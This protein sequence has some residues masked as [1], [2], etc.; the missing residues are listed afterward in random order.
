MVLAG[1]VLA[2]AGAGILFL[3]VDRSLNRVVSDGVIR[4]GYAVEAPYA[5]LKPG[6]EVSGEAPEVAKVIAAQLGIPRIEWRQMEFDA[7]IP[8]L[9]A[10]RIDVIAAGMFITPERARRVH[11]SKPTLRV[12]Q[13]LL[14]RSGNPL[15]IHSYAQ[16]VSHPDLK[17][18]VLSGS[19]EQR[20]LRRMGLPEDRTVAVPDAR[21]GR[22]AVESGVAGC[23]ALSL[24]SVRWLALQGL[25][26][27]TEA[28]TE[29]AEDAPLTPVEEAALTA[30]AFH[31][32]DR[33]LHAAW[34]RELEQFIGR[35]GHLAILQL[36]GLTPED[37]PDNGETGQEDTP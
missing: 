12:R 35:P 4:I 28:A 36:F 7:L 13:G 33:R 10:G 31:R 8:Q 16:A 32:K 22:V 5:F 14:T 20:L 37:L 2:L 18:A 11:F 34:D 30:F 26:G 29:L 25:P 6:G 3:P 15:Q 17:V 24:P 19:A 9:E 1:G 23:L 27:K 21:T